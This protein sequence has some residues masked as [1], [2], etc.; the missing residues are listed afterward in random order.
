MKISKI[1]PLA[2]VLFLVSFLFGTNNFVYSEQDPITKMNQLYETAAPDK[3]VQ[4]TLEMF[5]SL[6]LMNAAW[7]EASS[8]P[9]DTDTSTIITTTMRE[10]LD[11]NKYLEKSALLISAYE[12]DSNEVIKLAAGAIVTGTRLATSANLTF[13]GFIKQLAI[14][15][16]RPNGMGEVQFAGAKYQSDRKDAYLSTITGASGILMLYWEA[17]ET[18]NPTG[19]IRWRISKEQRERLLREI[20][21]LFGSD[22]KKLQRDRAAKTN[23]YAVIPVMITNIKEQL[24]TETYEQA[25]AREA[26]KR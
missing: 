1:T 22:L 4:F 11:S 25:R 21:R 20:E 7:P 24:S 5:S 12:E 9:A 18:P 14:V 23:N 17:P 10:L 6:H 15:A 16:T 3:L 13:L 2:S 19:A 8:L 26:G